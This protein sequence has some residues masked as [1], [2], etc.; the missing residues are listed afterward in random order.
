MSWPNTP[1]SEVGRPTRSC[2]MLVFV[3]Y[4]AE[5]VSSADVEV[6]ELL[7]FG[8]RIGG[9]P[10]R[11]AVQGAV[12]PVLVVVGLELAE[13]VEQVGLVPDQGAVEEFVSAGLY[14][15]FGDRV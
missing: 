13:C 7:W 4:A 12:V 6:V 11:R 2:G 1:I 14:P 9:R 3:E 8:D 10:E 5:S 15:P